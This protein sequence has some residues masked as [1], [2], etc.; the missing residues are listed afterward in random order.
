MCIS[1]HAQMV[2]KCPLP[3]GGSSTQWLYHLQSPAQNEN[4][5]CF[6]QRAEPETKHKRFLGLGTVCL[7]GHMSMRLALAAPL[8]DV[9]YFNII[10]HVLTYLRNFQA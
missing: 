4:R 6:V 7:Q 2:L 3:Q 5:R 10:T 1:Q 9:T 8:M